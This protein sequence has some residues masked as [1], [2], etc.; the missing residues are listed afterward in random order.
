MLRPEVSC[1]WCWQ[2]HSPKGPSCYLYKGIRR[3][4]L[5]SHIWLIFFLTSLFLCLSAVRVVWSCWEEAVFRSSISQRRMP[6]FTPAWR[7][8]PTQP[9]KPR[10]NSPYKV[11][12]ALSAFWLKIVTEEQKKNKCSIYLKK[13]SQSSCGSICLR[14][15]ET[16]RPYWLLLRWRLDFIRLPREDV[17]TYKKSA[18]LERWKQTHSI[19]LSLQINVLDD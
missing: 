10:P 8:M 13:L 19:W 9:L 7:T 3:N 4:I 12:S 11:P 5:F 1:M 15:C 14:K 18:V 16:R 17:L 2:W 6:A